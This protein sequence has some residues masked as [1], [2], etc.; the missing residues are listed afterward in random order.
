MEKLQQTLK[1]YSSVLFF[2]YFS[3]INMEIMNVKHEKYE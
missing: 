1:F 2:V 3:L